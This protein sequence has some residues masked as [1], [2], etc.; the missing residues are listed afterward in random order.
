MLGLTPGVIFVDYCVLR[1]LVNGCHGPSDSVESIARTIGLGAHE[2]QALT[3][4]AT[5]DPAL[6]RRTQNL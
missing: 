6:H 5:T 4:H 3:A 2:L 1:E